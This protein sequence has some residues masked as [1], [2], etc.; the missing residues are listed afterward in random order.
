[1]TVSTLPTQF[2]CDGLAL[3][4][5]LRLVGSLKIQ[6]S[7]AKEPY[8]RDHIFTFYDCLS[9]TDWY[10]LFPSSFF[11]VVAF[12]SPPPTWF[13][14]DLSRIMD[15]GGHLSWI[16]GGGHMRTTTT[17]ERRN[18][19]KHTQNSRKTFR[20]IG[21]RGKICCKSWGEV[22]A[23]RKNGREDRTI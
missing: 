11:V 19:L 23:T 10:L 8:K 22:P 18:T 17:K 1:M 7:F 16:M 6:V 15:G 20:I 9:T 2:F 5:W 4:G 14:K 13:M 21:G 12:I 3:V